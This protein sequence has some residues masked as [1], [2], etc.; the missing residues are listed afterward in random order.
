MGVNS[1]FIGVHVK[2]KNAINEFYESKQTTKPSNL[3]WIVLF[4][5]LPA[6]KEQ[7]KCFKKMQGKLITMKE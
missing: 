1:G 2:E 4:G 6:A 5:L 3:W 7:T